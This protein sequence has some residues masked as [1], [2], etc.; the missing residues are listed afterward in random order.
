MKCGQVQE[1]AKYKKEFKKN[2]IIKSL[3]FKQLKR[4]DKKN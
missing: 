1:T 3:Y 4:Q 2:Y